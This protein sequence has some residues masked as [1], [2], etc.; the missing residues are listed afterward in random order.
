MFFVAL[1]TFTL[2]HAA[3]GSPFDRNAN[4]PMSQATI[5]RTNR[6]YDVDKPVPQ[7]FVTYVGNLLKGDLGLSFTRQRPVV[8][9][10]G[11]GIGTTFQAGIS[12]APFALA[13]SIPL[14]AITALKNG[15]VPVATIIG[16]GTAGL[17]TGRFSIDTHFNVQGMGRLYVISILGRDYLVIM[18]TTLVYAFLIMI[19][20]LTEDNLYGVLDP[21]I[22]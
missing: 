11:Q 22:K 6:Y 19:A 10:I 8:D 13:F 16:P 7:Q 21:R 5:D 3:P 15:L 20:N 12:A 4:R 18:G 17:K 2:A 14:A 9:I 1:I